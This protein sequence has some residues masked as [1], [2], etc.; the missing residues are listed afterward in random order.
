MGNT[1]YLVSGT[2]RHVSSRS[3]G[4]DTN[5]SEDWIDMDTD[6]VTAWTMGDDIVDG[7]SKI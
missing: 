6:G 4:V 5:Q 2:E 7:S 1:L 3:G